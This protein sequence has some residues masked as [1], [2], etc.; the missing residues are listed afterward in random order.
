MNMQSSKKRRKKIIIGTIFLVLAGLTVA[1]LIKKREVVVPV[2]TQTVGHRDITEIVLADGKIH[3]VVQVKISPEVSGEI[4]SLPV[5]E[6]Q[7]VRQGELL[8]QIKPDFYAANVR[9]AEAAHQQA[10]AGLDLARAEEKK[11]ELEYNRVRE[12]YTT[13]VISESEFEASR[14]ARD[15]ALARTRQAE[16]QV[17]MAQ[18]SLASAQEDLSKT[19]IRSPLSGTVSKLNSEIGE[20]VLGTAQNMGT[21]IMVIS[22][23][24]AMEARVEIGEIDIVLICTGQ[25]AR[26][27]VDAFRDRKFTGRVTE[28]GNSAITTGRGTQEQATKFEVRVAIQEQ[29]PF[30]PGMSVSADIETRHRTNVIAVPI[31]CVTRRTLEKTTEPDSEMAP[32]PDDTNAPPAETDK[33]ESQ[34]RDVV[35]VV[36][37][38]EKVKAVPVERGISDDDYVEIE[39]GLEVG[40]EVVTGSYKAIRDLQDGDA[41]RVKPASKSASEPASSSPTS[42][43]SL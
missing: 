32:G 7:Y 31:Q 12:M 21:E 33:P 39:S 24:N 19:T 40:V 8:V 41:V 15:V 5:K 35:F 9:R 29:A 17:A 34:A 1:A 18:A 36:T 16:H 14:T 30:R 27:D 38:A 20:R 2:E 3:P 22:D 6:G 26:L 10:E 23:L 28:I 25:L 13:Q 43:T 4:I 37:D 11:A 42:S